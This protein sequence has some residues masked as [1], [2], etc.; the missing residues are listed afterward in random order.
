MPDERTRTALERLVPP[1]PAEEGWNDVL[2]RAERLRG[3]RRRG[4]VVT[5][6]AAGVLALGGSLAAS[7]EISSLLPHSKEPHLLLSAELRGRGGKRV[8][9]LQIELHP[10][11]SP[12]AAASTFGSSR[13][14]GRPR[15]APSRS[16]PP[17]GSCAHRPS[18]RRSHA[19]PS[20]SVREHD[21]EARP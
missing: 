15:T 14:H 21:R 6:V 3:R 7:G 5:G 20:S 13:R 19:A 12:S 4:R 2:L 18:T 17:A 11:S 1:V 10:L 9:T 8:G 16:S